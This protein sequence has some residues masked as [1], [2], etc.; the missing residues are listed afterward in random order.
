LRP[1]IIR[2]VIIFTSRFVR[3]VV[4]AAAITQVGSL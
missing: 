3:S 1:T 4:L 2:L